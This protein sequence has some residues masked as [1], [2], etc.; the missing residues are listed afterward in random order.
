MLDVWLEEQAEWGHC[1]LSVREGLEGNEANKRKGVQP[2]PLCLQS[3]DRD[4]TGSPKQT[5]VFR[6]SC[7]QAV[8]SQLQF[9]NG[10]EARLWLFHII[11]PTAL[12]S[13]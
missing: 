9:C 3:C 10:Q 7:E 8:G 4:P 6:L 12:L 13:E 11:P 2:R 1:T 5:I